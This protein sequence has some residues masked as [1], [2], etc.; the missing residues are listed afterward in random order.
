MDWRPVFKHLSAE[1][2]W[3]PGQIADLTLA[4]VQAYL[5]SDEG[6]FDSGRLAEAQMRFARAAAKA[7]ADDER[8][9]RR[10]KRG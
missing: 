7:K 6:G 5:G 3:T 8:A 10:L 1:Y 9:K 4:Q 2:G